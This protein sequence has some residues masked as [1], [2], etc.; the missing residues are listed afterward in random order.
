MSKF[1]LLIIFLDCHLFIHIS[2]LGRNQIIAGSLLER[3]GQW[4]NIDYVVRKP[5]IA[6]EGE[7][8]NC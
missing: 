1:F 3:I 8:L 4:I 2:E 6:G 5:R 7:T